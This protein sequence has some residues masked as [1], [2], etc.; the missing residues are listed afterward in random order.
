MFARTCA[1]ALLALGGCAPAAV[2]DDG[3][4]PAGLAAFAD[5]QEQCADAG[6]GREAWTAPAPPFRV[7]GNTYYVGTCGI[8][9]LLVTSG[10]GNVLL[11]TGM[12]DAAPLVRANV[13]RLGFSITSIKAL[14]SSHEHLDHVG[15]TAQVKRL[16]GARAVAL[17]AAVQPLESGAPYPQDPQ[18]AMIPHFEGFKI[19][20]V[21]R[22][23]ETF[24][25]G[26]LAF[27]GHSTPSHTPGS[28]SWTWRSC[29][30]E[31]CL[32][33]AYADSLTTP[34]ADGYRFGDHPEYVAQVRKGFD[35][36]ANLPCDIL[37]T[38]HPGAS[39]MAE[40]FSGKMA[41]VDPIGCKHYAH[42][43]AA[44]FEQVLAKEA[45]DAR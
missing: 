16:S 40:R 31:R 35:V 19:D 33:I 6:P 44:R 27:T 30:G 21:L 39:D 29:E 45:A 23:G 43:A 18:A 32:T 25:L 15:A 20:T 34:A 41:I 4:Q 12:P 11:D 5:W 3:Q 24:M 22:D 42:T 17:E 9:A 38:P 26:P 1:L 10:E 7:F 8:A 36:V 28:T 37:M 14:L 2:A 13:E